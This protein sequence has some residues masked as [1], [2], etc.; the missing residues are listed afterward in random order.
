V[1]ALCTPTNLLGLP[2][3]AATDNAER[4]N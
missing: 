2:V 1:A 4:K 3:E